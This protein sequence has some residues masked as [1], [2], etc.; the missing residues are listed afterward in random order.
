VKNNMTAHAGTLAQQ[1][2]LKD[3]SA[4][5]NRRSMFLGLHFPGFACPQRCN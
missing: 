3:L 1:D 2:S 4:E 5:Q